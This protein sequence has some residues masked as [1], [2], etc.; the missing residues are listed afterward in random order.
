MNTDPRRRDQPADHHELAEML[1]APGHP[2]LA[3]DRH[4]VLREHLM[5]HMTHETAPEQSGATPPSPT[6]PGRRRPGRRLVLVAAPL[7]LA[8][9]VGLG[10]VAVDSAQNGKGSTAT[11][12]DRRQA[13]RLLNRIALAAAGRPAVPVRDDQY[14]YTKSQGSARE[15]GVD[16][17]R[18]E[19]LAKQQGDS[20]VPEYQGPV[21]AEEWQPVDGKRDGLRTGVAVTD[22]SQRMVMD[23]RGVG[24]LTFRQL[25]A[26][27]TDPDA[28]LKRLYGD[29]GN[30]EP[31]RRA[32]T[33]LENIGVIIDSATLLPDL[34]AAIYRAM[35]ELPGARVVDHAKDAAGRTG[36]GL[37][38]TDSPEGYAWV[39][40]SSSLVYLG[41]TRTAL[42]QVGVTDRKGEE[43][44]GS[45]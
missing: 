35:A 3:Q 10:A 45:S 14:I 34:S 16:F 5:A 31:S 33:A 1:P 28:L 17:T 42:L 22:P 36:V 21:R 4:R 11:A 20:R 15:L 9:V 25:Q 43:P 44:A 32:E 12:G 23:M 13:E 8:A 2:V 30:V 27:P 26:L 19:E 37:T 38:F 41:T 39:F 6:A 7:A 18:A 40:D 24:Y 29:A